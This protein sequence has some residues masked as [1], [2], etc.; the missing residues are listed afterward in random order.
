MPVPVAIPL[1]QLLG[2]ASTGAALGK[3][4]EETTPTEPTIPFSNVL[5]RQFF[6][7]S[8]SMLQRTIDTPSG[9]VFAPDEPTPAKPNI[10]A[11]YPQS[12]D[13]PWIMSSPIPAGEPKGLM[14][15]PMPE[16]QD[17]LKGFEKP[18][19][20]DTSVLKNVPI[21]KSS[22]K[23]Q[24]YLDEKIVDELLKLRGGKQKFEESMKESMAPMPASTKNKMEIILQ[25][26]LFNKYKLNEYPEG[27]SPDTVSEERKQKLINTYNKNLEA[28]SYITSAAYD[29]IPGPNKNTVFVVDNDG[30]PIA[31]AKIGKGDLLGNAAKEAIAIKEVGSINSNA[32]NDLLKE[33]NAR[34]LVN[35]K[36]YIVAEDIT[37]QEAIDAFKAKGFEPASLKKYK[38]FEGK[39]IYRPGGGKKVKQKNYVKEVEGYE[40]NTSNPVGSLIDKPLS[41]ETN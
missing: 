8:S 29:A 10:L 33:I 40:E 12:K 30:L 31:G 14:G 25:E 19:D 28:I 7:P 32:T 21:D 1:S 23:T 13:Q 26:K 39:L 17:K 9:K 35:G 22:L 11:T 5:A 16:T 27:E 38:Q 18:Q 6:G 24:D 15:L 2:T 36:K 37:S 34:A 41:D 3:P 4:T 20:V